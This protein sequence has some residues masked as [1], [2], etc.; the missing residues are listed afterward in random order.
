MGG[1]CDGVC[2]VGWL[3]WF[4]GSGVWV[5][6]RNMNDD[7]FNV[8]EEAAGVSFLKAEMTKQINKLI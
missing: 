1:G 4:I 2:E 7:L 8:I 3:S 5:I 6:E